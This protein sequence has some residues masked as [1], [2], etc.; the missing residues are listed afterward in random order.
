MPDNLVD[1]SEQR[2][3]RRERWSGMRRDW[4]LL[5]IDW[6]LD[7]LVPGRER[8]RIL[9]ALRESIDVESAEIPLSEVLAGLGSPRALALSHAE[10]SPLRPRWI[11][12]IVTAAVALVLYWAVFFSYLWG[13]L[14]VVDQFQLGEVHSRFLLIEVVAFAEADRFG[15]GWGGEPSWLLLPLAIIGAVFLATSRPWRALAR[16]WRRA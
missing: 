1:L 13:M 4:Y 9:R 14:A 11:A 3:E 2:E 6:Y 7:P 12:G 16:G 8:R 5:R 15:V 10:G